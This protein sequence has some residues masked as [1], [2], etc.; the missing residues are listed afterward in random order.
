MVDDGMGCPE[1]LRCISRTKP[2]LLV[3]GHIHQAHG[4][5]KGFG[6]CRQTWFVNASNAGWSGLSSSER[7]DVNESKGKEEGRL[8]WPPVVVEI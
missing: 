3:G 8:G 5:R 1:L 6:T 2:K 4:T 7:T